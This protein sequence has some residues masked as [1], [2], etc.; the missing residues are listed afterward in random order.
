MKD[1]IENLRS[2]EEVELEAAAAQA[3]LVDG[4]RDKVQEYFDTHSYAGYRSG[5]KLLGLQFPHKGNKSLT[6]TVFAVPANVDEEIMHRDDEWESGL[7]NLGKE[8]G[9][10]IRIP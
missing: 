8:Y 7:N 6:R 1:L 10:N 2:L 5:W 4:L 9:V 3:R